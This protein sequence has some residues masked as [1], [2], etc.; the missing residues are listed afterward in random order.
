MSSLDLLHKLKLATENVA[1][2]GEF[3][4]STV[5]QGSNP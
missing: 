1:H 3:G 4:E 5:M 2:A